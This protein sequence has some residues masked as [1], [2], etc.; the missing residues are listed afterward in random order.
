MPEKPS[1]RPPMIHLS[2]RKDLRPFLSNNKN[3]RGSVAITTAACPELIYCSPSTTRPEPP[4]SIS[5]P[6]MIYTLL[7]FH[8]GKGSFL[9]KQPTVSE[10]H[11]S[12]L[13]SHLNLV[14][15]L[16]LEKK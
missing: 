16:L 3:S 1:S 10:E 11:T 5:R 7:F 2:F 8:P 6:L 13:Q 12:E 9:I 14:C 4:T 15:R